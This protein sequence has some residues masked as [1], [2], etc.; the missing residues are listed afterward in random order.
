M[1]RVVDLRMSE[2]CVGRYS[3]DQDEPTL[4]MPAFGP[5]VAWPFKGRVLRAIVS[6]AGDEAF[7]MNSLHTKL[8]QLFPDGNETLFSEASGKDMYLHFWL[9]SVHIPERHYEEDE[10]LDEAMSELVDNVVTMLR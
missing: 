10:K 5:M 2:P 7:E 8:N 4:S 3:G 9:N 6:S 1:R